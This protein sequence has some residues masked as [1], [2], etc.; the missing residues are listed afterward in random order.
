MR[1]VPDLFDGDTLL[2]VLPTWTPFQD[3]DATLDLRGLPAEVR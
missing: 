1:E 2:E 3:F